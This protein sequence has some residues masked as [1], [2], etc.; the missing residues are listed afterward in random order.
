M[1]SKGPVVL[2]FPR[3]ETKQ[4]R[5][6]ISPEHGL[7]IQSGIQSQIECIQCDKGNPMRVAT[8]LSCRRAD[9]AECPA[10]GIVLE[11]FADG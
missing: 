4:D 10:T 11:Q 7:R 6:P 5:G 9:Q 1:I 2:A 8:G 3:A